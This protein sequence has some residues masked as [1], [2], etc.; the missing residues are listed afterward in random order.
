MPLPKNLNAYA[1]VKAILDAALDNL[2]A[3]YMV[4]THNEAVRW[5][6]EA[7]YFRKLSQL[8]G[9]TRY[10]SLM[11]KLDDNRII[12]ESRSVTGTLTRE[13]GKVVEIALAETPDTTEEFAFALAK[14]LGVETKEDE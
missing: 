13:D 11:F 9:D 14:R 2:P 4:A 12:I 8:G 7:Y 10:D 3:K 5:R 1:N 6:Q